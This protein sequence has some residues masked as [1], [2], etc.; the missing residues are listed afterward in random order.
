MTQVPHLSGH[1]LNQFRVAVPQGQNPGTGQEVK[2]DIVI[3]VPHER[4]GTFGNRNGKMPWIGAGVGFCSFLA[5]Q[6][7][8]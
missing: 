3:D 2:E 5:R 1:H 8:G 6:Q 7:F 4:T